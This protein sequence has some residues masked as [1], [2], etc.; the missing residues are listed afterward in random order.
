MHILHIIFS[1][2]SINRCS[3]I[4]IKKFRKHVTISS[5]IISI[6]LVKVNI[7]HAKL[8]TIPCNITQDRGIARNAE[9]TKKQG[10]LLSYM[11]PN[12]IINLSND[13]YFVYI[14]FM[15]FHPLETEHSERAL[16]FIDRQ[17]FSRNCQTV[18]KAPKTCKI[19]KN[20][21]KKIFTKPHC[22][23]F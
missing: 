12:C 14:L 18:F 16:R 4:T 3:D 21:K 1:A 5:K 20:R 15:Q 22:K 8:C 2:I 19:I 23:F 13:R 17:T 7:S 9:K 6:L 10:P 11:Y